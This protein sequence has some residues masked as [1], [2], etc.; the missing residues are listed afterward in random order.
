VQHVRGNRVRAFRT[1]SQRAVK[2]WQEL[3][4][5]KRHAPHDAYSSCEVQIGKLSGH[6]TKFPAC[7]GLAKNAD[8]LLSVNYYERVRLQMA[9]RGVLHRASLFRDKAADKSQIR[10]NPGA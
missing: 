5:G 10:F 7:L 1:C 8:H 6:V 9:R 2:L 3:E 4:L